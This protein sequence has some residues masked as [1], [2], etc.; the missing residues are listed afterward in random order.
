MATLLEKIAAEISPEIPGIDWEALEARFGKPRELL[1]FDTGGDTPDESGAFAYDLFIQAARARA[2]AQLATVQLTFQ[3]KDDPATEEDEISLAMAAWEEVQQE[4]TTIGGALLRALQNDRQFLSSS[5][6]F[7][8]SREAFRASISSA[9]LICL[10]GAL[11]HLKKMMQFEEMS[12]E[13]I[14]QSA[15]DVTRMFNAL[16]ILG[17]KGA[18]DVLRPKAT[19]VVQAPVVIV[20]S[21]AAVFVVSAIAY[22]YVTAQRQSAVNKAMK[23]ICEEAQ[24]TGDAELLEQCSVLAGKNSGVATHG[25]AERMVLTIGQAALMVGGAYALILFAPHLARLFRGRSRA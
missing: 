22:L 10:Y 15:D 18:L 14:V 12:G 9:Y 20:V 5:S 11:I 2:E 19:G 16:A 6:S 25:P 17:E 3:V 21:I 13:A 1:V 23:I 24:R 7:E 8:I 4:Q